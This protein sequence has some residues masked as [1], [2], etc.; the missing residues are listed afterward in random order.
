MNPKPLIYVPPDPHKVDQLAQDACMQL[1]ESE[2]VYADPNVI[3]GLAAFL[4]VVAVIIAKGLNKGSD[5]LLKS[6][7]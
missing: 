5:E 6:D 3:G 2:P 4:N 7:G 1:A